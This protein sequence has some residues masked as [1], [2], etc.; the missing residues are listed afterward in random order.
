MAEAHRHDLHVDAGGER[1][2][3]ALEYADQAL[4]LGTRNALFHFHRGM[5]RHATGDQAGARADL[6][7]ALSIN[8]HFSPLHAPVAH[9]TLAALEAR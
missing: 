3:E 1:K 6:E 2:G 7:R 9:T 5:I 4:R 8:P